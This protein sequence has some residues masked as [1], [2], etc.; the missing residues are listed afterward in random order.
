MKNNSTKYNT[1]CLIS[2]VEIIICTEISKHIPVFTDKDDTVLIK[3]ARD[4][5]VVNIFPIF[6]RPI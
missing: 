1:I 3:T 6:E 5:N 4:I 2:R